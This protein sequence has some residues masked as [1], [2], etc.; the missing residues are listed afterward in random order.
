MSEVAILQRHG[1]HH[2]EIHG[3]PVDVPGDGNCFFHSLMI[4]KRTFPVSDHRALRF[5]AYDFALQVGGEFAE[6]AFELTRSNDNTCSLAPGEK[7]H[8][9]REDVF[10][11]AKPSIGP[12]DR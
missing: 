4:F 6:K 5:S 10:S 3:Y 8:I 2:G 11:F 7:Y 1:F 12:V 9:L